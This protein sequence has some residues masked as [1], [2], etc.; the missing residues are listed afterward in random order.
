MRRSAPISQV[1]VNH[2]FQSILCVCAAALAGTAIRAG[3][4]AS[5]RGTCWDTGY[6]LPCARAS[7]LRMR[8]LRETVRFSPLT[9]EG[10]FGVS[11]CIVEIAFNDGGEGSIGTRHCGPNL[12]NQ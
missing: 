1:A 11:V 6:E 9:M 10:V 4:S 2:S 8:C 3:D 12:I 7:V 5:V